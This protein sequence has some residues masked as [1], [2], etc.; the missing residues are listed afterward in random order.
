M[1]SS[2]FGVWSTCEYYHPYEI[3]VT[4]LYANV[5]VI[6]S[7]LVRNCKPLPGNSLAATE[8]LKC[9]AV[10]CKCQRTFI[11]PTYMVLIPKGEI[12]KLLQLCKTEE[13]FLM[14]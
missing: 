9:W 2:H 11:L 12:M 4:S 3:S 5:Q 13:V 14:C 10:T 7:L 8:V 1:F 6:I